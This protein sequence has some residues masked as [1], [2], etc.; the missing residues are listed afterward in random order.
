MR[1]SQFLVAT[2]AAVP[3]FASPIAK[4]QVK[5]DIDILNYAL[6]LVR[7]I[8]PATRSALIVV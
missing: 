7:T 2:L 3:S 6:T 1:A 8:F 5:S 4:R